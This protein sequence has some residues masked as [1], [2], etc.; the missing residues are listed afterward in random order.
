MRGLVTCYLLFLTILSYSQ[1]SISQPPDQT[2]G[3]GGEFETIQLADVTNAS[4]V[5]WEATFLKPISEESDPGWSF[6]AADFQFQM[7]IT[8]SIV[9]KGDRAIGDSHQLAVFDDQETIRGIASAISVGTD[10]I[11]FLTINSNDN[12]ETLSFRFFDDSLKQTLKGQQTFTFSSNQIIGQ[13]DDP[14]II[15]AT[16]FEIGLSE[17][18]LDLLIKDP[19]F[20]GTERI[21]LVARSLTN[22]NDFDA[23]TISFTVI[24]DFVPILSGISDETTNFDE[25]FSTFDL[26]DFTTLPDDDLVAF[27]FAG[28]Q[29]LA[30]AIDEDNMVSVTKP[31]DW[32]GTETI[33]FT[34]TDLTDNAFSS[35]QQVI[36]SGK[37]ADQAPVIIHIEDKI[38]G[39]QGL[40]ETIDLSTFITANNPE[41]ITWDYEVITDSTMSAPDWTINAKEFQFNMSATIEASSMGKSLIGDEHI[42]AAFSGK[43][44]TLIG[45]ANATI[46]SNEWFYFLTIYNNSS[47]DS[48]YFKVYD[49]NVQ[50]VLPTNQ[51]LNFTANDVVGDPLEPL[52][53]EAG[54]LFPKLDKDQLSF[55]LR[56]TNWKGTEVIKISATDSQTD[57]LLNDKDTVNF[58][59]L[60]LRPPML[61]NIEDKAIQEGNAFSRI[62]LTDFLSNVSAAEVI[63][64][65]AG[66]DTLQPKLDGSL[67]TFELASEHYFGI[68]NLT[69]TAT[70]NV[71]SS[72][73]D[74]VT[75][76]LA[77]ANI[78]DVPVIT[79]TPLSDGEV[80]KVYQYDL[81]VIDYDNDELTI[82]VSNLPS[83]LYFVNQQN[84]ATILG[85]PS[86]E[87][88]GLASFS[89]TVKDGLVTSTQ[90]VNIAIA[91]AKM[92]TIPAQSINEGLN[93]SPIPL[94]DYVTI[95]GDL[96]VSWAASTT[97]DLTVEVINNVLQVNSPDNNWYGQEN[98]IVTMTDSK[99]NVY[100]QNV[101][102]TVNN[103]NDAPV[104]TS[105]PVVDARVNVDYRYDLAANDIDNSDLT[106]TIDTP[107]SWLTFVESK[108]GGAFIGTPLPEH[109]GAN[110]FIINVADEETSVNQTV[111]IFVS[112]AAFSAIDDQTIEEGSSFE[113]LDLS[114][115]LTVFGDITTY[116]KVSGQS[117]LTAELVDGNKLS[118]STPNAD[119]FGDEA[120]TIQLLDIAD[121][122]VLDERAVNFIVNNVNDAPVIASTPPNAARV[123]VDYRYDLAAND[124]DNSD[125]TITVATPLSWLTFV[126]S[127]TGGAFI[128]KP[129]PE[130]AGTNSFIINVSDDVTSVD[131]TVDIFVSYV[132]FSAID[133]QSIEEGSAFEQV[134]LSSFLSVFGDITTSWKISGQSELTA[135]LVD[136]NKLSVTIPN[137]DWFGA[138][139][140]TLQLIDLADDAVLDEQVINFAVSNI[141]DAP[142]IS[143]THAN[144]A[145]VNVDYR[146][147]LAVSDIDNSNLTVTFATPLSWLTFVESKSGGAFI[148]TPLPEHAGANSFIINVA[149]DD[150]SV[151]QT[152]DIFVSYAA[153][154]AIDNQSIDEGSAFEQVDLSSFLSVF[155]DITTYWKVSGQSELTAELVD[156]NKLYV[157]IPDSDWFGAEALTLQLI[158]LAD[159]AV[160]DEQVINF[161][162]SN[163]N[164]AP[165]I[166]STHANAARVNVAYRYDLAVSDIDD[167]NLTITVA[168]P[169]SW[170][171][172]VESKSGGAFIGTPL[173][174][175]A[176]ENSFV[177]NVADD[178]TSVD[179]TVDIFVSYAAFSAI[180]N[181]SIDEGSA[182]EQVDLSSFLTVFGDIT[183]YWKISGQSELAAELVDGNKLSVTI[184]NSDWFGAEAFTLQLID[185][186]DDT[187][188]DEQVINFAVNN[189]NDAPVF[190]VTL[191]E[192]VLPG[193]NFSTTIAIADVDE[194]VLTYEVS[195][196]SDWLTVVAENNGIIIFGTSPNQAD[197]VNFSVDISDG[198]MT[199]TFTGQIIVD[200]VLAH[201]TPISEVKFFPNPAQ[202]FVYFE[203]AESISGI[204]IIDLNGKSV[205]SIQNPTTEPIDIR[206]LKASIYF[207]KYEVNGQSRTKKIILKR[208]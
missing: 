208:N 33:T 143:S 169:L 107:L 56:A 11:Y 105:S 165:I 132:T 150:T 131:Q 52:K 1:V 26:D 7:N 44:H 177:I 55:S 22:P 205:L 144:A 93:F 133:N 38:T 46:V 83:W 68:E 29:S 125:L 204:N 172:F 142:I 100:S 190:K 183:T 202:D 19:S 187:V 48:V 66:A 181:Q 78:N 10:W 70:S 62:E 101:V 60:D 200:F 134:D 185:L 130:H 4:N 31:N 114:S 95:F 149:D 138:E 157:T 170:L 2:I 73:F 64:T 166:S 43:D 36:F 97:G 32:F 194:D 119:W 104:I 160:L 203:N 148:G 123:N 71:N 167:S 184:P 192:I 189:V 195:L 39:L 145:R 124:I 69:V 127:K 191:E 45:A 102:Y 98:I 173:P 41:S 109:A 77:T 141:N 53:L 92:E 85:I 188:L 42:I 99:S 152:V 72:L 117:E 27:S 3:Q 40:F 113:Q 163:I 20:V 171:T 122:A 86:S 136:G 75:L 65:I 201:T 54:Y 156:G 146:Y 79:T 61:A 175:H 47:T 74:L 13:P 116:W 8:A 89:I 164:D 197:T 24:D 179:Q 94:S 12:G 51:F 49:Q 120:L 34:V 6:N 176:G 108:T 103:I 135:E 88:A 140:L 17:N 28:N 63:W 21:R 80:D 186:A 35:S 126:E 57:Q 196:T 198:T 121:D 30:V 180:D 137:S 5:F 37:P 129:L 174:E 155:G 81:E 82:E 16:N 118:V 159:D 182:F 25:A 23:D 84:K 199:S 59:V 154:S 67:L 162:V 106:I 96:T 206:H 153:F 15:D 18:T 193:V 128:G 147:D 91:F 87:D 139:A 58:I 112:Y 50:R 168:T 115:F 9:S 90:E 158:D 178:E 161:A 151:D 76:Q 110:S 14:L 111:D 207:I